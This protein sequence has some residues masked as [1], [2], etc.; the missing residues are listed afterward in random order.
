MARNNVPASLSEQF[1]CLVHRLCLS[2]LVSH[3]SRTTAQYKINQS[4][5]G[6]SKELIY[7]LDRWQSYL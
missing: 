6:A 7:L 5:A 4:L 1:G 3:L 2:M